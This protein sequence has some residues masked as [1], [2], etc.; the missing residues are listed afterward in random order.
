MKITAERPPDF[1]AETEQEP[2]TERKDPHTPP[3]EDFST[4]MPSLAKTLKEGGKTVFIS[5][6]YVSDD[7]DF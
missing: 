6:P 1:D 4:E 5:L 7:N 3:H 2:G